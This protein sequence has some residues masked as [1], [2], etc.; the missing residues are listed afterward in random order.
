MA[1]SADYAE[2]SKEEQEAE[3]VQM[4]LMDREI[5]SLLPKIKAAKRL[6]DM[7][8]RDCLK[9]DVTMSKVAGSTSGGKNDGVEVKVIVTKTDS[10]ENTYLDTFEFEKGL[11]VLK[12][13]MTR[14]RNAIDN[15]REYVVSEFA[16]PIN[17]FFDNT[18]LIGTATTFPEFLGY[19][20]E[21]EAADKLVRL[22]QHVLVAVA[23]DAPLS[24][25]NEVV[26]SFYRGTII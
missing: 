16:D 7:L 18:Y 11:S 14:L 9:F 23:W 2:L 10:K 20:L 4:Q 15:D 6:V 22:F 1:R 24:T 5:T 21:T 26:C 12:D 8:D 17:V 19:M 3:D 13:E 25:F